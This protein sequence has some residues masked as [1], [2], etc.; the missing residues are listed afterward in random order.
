MCLINDTSI[1]KNM[2]RILSV[3]LCLVM[4]MVLYSHIVLELWI[5]IEFKKHL[6]KKY[7]HISHVLGLHFRCIVFLDRY[8]C[9][10][11]NH[12]LNVQSITVLYL[13]NSLMP[14]L[15][16]KLLIYELFTLFICFCSHYHS[17]FLTVESYH[18]QS[19]QYRQW[20]LD[21]LTI[22]YSFV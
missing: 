9:I 20:V 7:I 14:I 8:K 21:M 3:V 22:R 5:L 6:L 18:L 4:P 13:G 19:S 17:T 15:L 12:L 16:I 1:V 10:G 11:Y 2:P